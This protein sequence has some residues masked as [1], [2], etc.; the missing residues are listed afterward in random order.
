MTTNHEWTLDHVIEYIE[1][2][3][4]EDHVNA[5]QAYCGCSCAKASETA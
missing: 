3:F 4:G 1:N 5:L 2:E